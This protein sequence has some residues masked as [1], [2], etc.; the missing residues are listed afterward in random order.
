MPR[1]LK[2]RHHLF[3]LKEKNETVEF[4]FFCYP[5]LECN[6]KRDLWYF[7]A[8]KSLKKTKN[9]KCVKCL[10]GVENPI[11]CPKSI[12]CFEGYPQNVVLYFIMYFIMFFVSFT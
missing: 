5:S 2:D 8:G 9:L 10:K 7:K 12:E 4:L 6:H 11:R 3:F 1:R